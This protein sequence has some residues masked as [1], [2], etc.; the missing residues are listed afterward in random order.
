MIMNMRI[1]CFEAKVHDSSGPFPKTMGLRKSP[2]KS[3]SA[4]AS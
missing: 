4:Q 1:L 3:L 2:S